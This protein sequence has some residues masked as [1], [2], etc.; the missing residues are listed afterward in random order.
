[1]STAHDE[2]LWHFL[3]PARRATFSALLFSIAGF[4]LFLAVDYKAW[5]PITAPQVWPVLL[6]AAV[7]VV[8]MLTLHVFRYRGDAILAAATLVLSG[9]GVLAQ[10]RMGSIDLEAGLQVGN[11]AFP[12]GALLMLV[13]A[14]LFKNNRYQMLAKL[15]PLCGYLVILG[16]AALL[17]MGNRYR[18]GVYGPGFFT[19]TELLKIPIVLFLAAYMQRR[20]KALQDVTHIGL[21]LPIRALFPLGVYWLVLAG[22][23]VIQRDLGMFVILSS[24]MIT[25]L[26]LTTNRISYLFY[27]ML[28]ASGFGYLAFIYLEHGSKRFEAWLNPFNDATGSGWQILQG[29][30]G[31]YAGGFW[32]AGFGKG[33]PERIPIAESDFIYA[34][35]GEELGFLGCALL[36]MIF[37]GL[38]HRAYNTA[39]RTKDPFGQLLIAGLIS[40]LSAQTFLNLAGVTKLLPLTGVPLPFISHGGSSMLTCF[41]TIGLIMAISASPPKARARK[42]TGAK[43]KSPARKKAPAKKKTAKKKAP[44]KKKSPAR[45]KKSPSRKK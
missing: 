20:I 11:L 16:I 36:V 10:T 21:G 35:L 22:L 28:G 41:A 40:I 1:M 3:S 7:C 19:P 33:Q 38:F 4:I 18:G 31:M 32:G 37:L 42:K 39:A 23:L 25:M 27:S 13:T 44:T 12:I 43:K 6:Y 24:V 29:L 30:S 45:K 26:F 15:G 34:A 5:K 2:G 9:F 14:L 8:V 17:F